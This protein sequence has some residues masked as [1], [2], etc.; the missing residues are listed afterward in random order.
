M[1]AIRDFRLLL[2]GETISVLGTQ[3]NIVAL[4]W[5]VLGF[6]NSALLLGTVLMVAAVPRA[7]FM[8]FG[9]AVSDRYSPKNLM[10]AS[11]LARAVIV[12]LIAVISWSGS[13]NVSLFVFLI[14]LFGVADAFFYPA[15]MSMLPKLLK[16]SELGG[17]NSL[18]Q[19]SAQ[20]MSLIG[21]STAGFIVA[22]T[23]VTAAFAIDA[24]SFVLAAGALILIASGSPA[25]SQPATVGGREILKSIQE[26]L[27]YAWRDALL[28]TLLVITA[29]VNIAF[30]GPF[31]VGT[32]LLA[33]DVFGSAVSLGLMLGA[34][35]AGALVGT[36]AAGFWQPQRLRGYVV[37]ALPLAI[38]VG[39]ALLAA[40]SQLEQAIAIRVGIGLATGYSNVFTVTLLQQHISKDMMGR[41]MSLVMFVS[42]GLHPISYF[43]SGLFASVGIGALFS[44]GA[45]MLIGVSLVA[46]A[47]RRVRDF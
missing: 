31:V 32:A 13:N 10:I 14:F 16:A 25:K 45:A 43:L 28:R 33:H 35:G 46:G 41:V 9:G 18:L 17:G 47:S 37:L 6:S 40:V 20:L 23:G 24:V 44:I 34:S 15:F 7:V 29:V 3:F 12:S 36:L 26:G 1:F 38:G 27:L 5:L 19:G 2:V 22:A 21:P 42:L 30:M 11:N 39:L 4:Q 8:I